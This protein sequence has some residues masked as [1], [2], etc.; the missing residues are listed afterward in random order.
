MEWVA[1][2][3][4]WRNVTNEIEQDVRRKT[5]EIIDL[6]MGIVTGGAL[7]VDYLAIHE[8]IRLDMFADRIK[9]ILPTNLDTYEKH[10]RKRASEGIITNRQASQLIQQL[11]NIK[12]K[13]PKAVK[14][15]RYAAV[16]KSS[17]YRRN[18]K[19]IDV[20]DK[21]IAF[22]V[23]K[24]EGTQDTIDK[25]NTRKIPVELHEYSMKR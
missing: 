24:S 4:S 19:I 21:I 16:N 23:N 14:E 20:A 8:A 3:G 18:S 9:I 1:I 12:S 6:G 2:V 22:Q 5:K 17:Y 25:A 7:G 13:N 15:L 11:R 10:Y